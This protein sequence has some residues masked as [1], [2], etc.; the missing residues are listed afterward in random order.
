M[1]N[2]GTRASSENAEPLR[3]APSSNEPRANSCLGFTLASQPLDDVR[4]R[5][6]GPLPE[7]PQVPICIRTVPSLCP[8]HA[9]ELDDYRPGSRGGSFKGGNLAAARDEVA[10]KRLE[11]GGNSCAVGFDALVIPQFEL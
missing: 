11:R 2:C 8:L 6:A 10:P 1:R 9:W 7:R 4:A 5:D 3:A